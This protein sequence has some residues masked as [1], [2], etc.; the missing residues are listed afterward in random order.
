MDKE[1]L[2]KTIDSNLQRS[3][4][5]SDGAAIRELCVFVWNTALG[6]CEDH[7]NLTEEQQEILKNIKINI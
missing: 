2:I 3:F 4:S 7:L 6:Q 5:G 1:E